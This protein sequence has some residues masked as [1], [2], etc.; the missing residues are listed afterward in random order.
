MASGG[1]SFEGTRHIRLQP[2]DINVPILLRFKA[3][4]AATAID[5]NIPYGS[6]I[7]SITYKMFNYK[8]VSTTAMIAIKRQSSNKCYCYLNYSSGTTS[9]STGKYKLTATA[10]LSL[11]GTTSVMTRQY[12]LDRIYRGN[13]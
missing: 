2:G 13:R 3:C 6:T 5:G 10:V 7:T 4:S 8:N 11:S 12:D 1:D 9:L